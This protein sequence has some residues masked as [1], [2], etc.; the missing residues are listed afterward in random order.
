MEW[1]EIKMKIILISMPFKT[2]IILIKYTLEL[3]ALRS[4]YNFFYL[5]NNKII[6]F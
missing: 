4:Y 2:L 1:S 6:K 3:L 5:F